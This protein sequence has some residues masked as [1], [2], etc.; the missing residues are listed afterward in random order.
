MTISINPTSGEKIGE[1]K[2]NTPEELRQMVRKARLAQPGWAATPVKDRINHLLKVRD[3]IAANVDNIADII[4][5]ENGKTRVDALATE[6]LSSAMAIDFYCRHAAE[7]LKEKM[8]PMGNILLANKRS[9]LLRI[10][11]GVIGVVSPWNYPFTIPFSDVIIALLAGNAVI[12][13]AASAAQATG[14]MLK[15]CIDSA[16]LPDGVFGYINLPGPVAGDT[17]LEAGIDKLMFT[18]SVA[19]GKTL[20]KKAADTL[21]PLLLELGG[22]DAMIVCEDAD[23]DRAVGGA[24]W[25]GF[26]TAGQSCAGVERIYVDKAV[27]DKFLLL[28]KNKIESLRIGPDKNFNVEMGS[29]TLK[30]QV[31]KVKKHLEDALR[32]GATIF[33]RQDPP[34]GSNEYFLPAMVLTEV[35]HD[36]LVM[37]EETFGPIVGVMKVENM[38]EAVRLANDSEL[39]LTGSVWSRNRRKAEAIARRI[40]AGV[41]T[42]N[43]HL[44]SHGM[45]ETPWGGFKLSGFG[46]THSSLG[47]EEVT[48]TQ[49][50]I[51]DLLPTK[52]N[53]WWFPSEKGLYEGLRGALIALYG[54]KDRLKGVW[55][56]LKIVPRLFKS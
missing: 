50:I 15:D 49:T 38:D 47:F 51:H 27:Y 2:V 52:R 54:K 24:T 35:N 6:V 42:I 8:L 5:R 12:L 32:K 43:D 21:T 37:R 7:Y 29:L 41:I 20:M 39:G 31:D 26:S 46:R 36:M 11:Y 17:F 56:L 44:M 53:L 55:S 33:A 45:A 14:K 48:K 16:D 34:A 40:E 23:L 19:T 10:P 13:K 4:S 3:Y 9:K 1:F 25:A 28:L 30:R 18:G 22:K